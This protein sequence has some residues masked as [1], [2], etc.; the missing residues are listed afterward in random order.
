MSSRIQRIRDLNQDT[1]AVAHE[2]IGTHGTPVVKVFEDFEALLHNRVALLTL[3]VGD[4]T[5]TAGI[6]RDH[7]AVQHGRQ[8]NLTRV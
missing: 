7:I 8:A 1:G 6:V 3:N 4:K 5:H 2:R